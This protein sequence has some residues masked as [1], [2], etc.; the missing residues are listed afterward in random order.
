MEQLVQGVP[1][2]ASIVEKI[3]AM[4]AKRNAAAV[5]E[6]AKDGIFLGRFALNP[7]TREQVP[8]WVGNFVLMEYGTGAIMAVPGHDERDFEF[9]AKYKLPIKVVV[10]AERLRDLETTTTY[11]VELAHLL[12]GSR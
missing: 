9:A 7:F 2:E 4:K 6:T 11:R 10:R 1:G 5:G 8:I 12:L 3:N